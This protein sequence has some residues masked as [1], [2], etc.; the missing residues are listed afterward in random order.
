MPEKLLAMTDKSLEE[1]RQ[2]SLDHYGI[3]GSENEQEFDD[4]AKIAAYICETKICLISFVDRDRLWFKSNFGLEAKQLERQNSFCNKVVQDGGP[5]LIR[6]ALNDDRFKNNR[7]VREYPDVRFYA[8][9]A[10]INRE[11][12][13]LGT[14]CVMDSDEKALSAS[15]IEHLKALG[16]QV[17]ALLEKRYQNLIHEGSSYSGHKNS[18]VRSQTQSSRFAS[19]FLMNRADAILTPLNE[20][21]ELAQK[22]EENS[23]DQK[24]KTHS[25]SILSTSTG[26]LNLLRELLDFSKAEAGKLELQISEFSL[27]NLMNSVRALFH[28]LM[29]DKGITFE[30]KFDS[31][32]G[33]KYSG[34]LTRIQQILNQLISNSIQFTS[35]G[36]IALS[37]NLNSISTDLTELEFSVTDTGNGMSA[38]K[39]NS[40]FQQYSDPDPTSL[41]AHRGM[42][43]GLAMCK[44]LSNLMNGAMGVESIEGVGSTFLFSVK[45]KSSSDSTLKLLDASSSNHAPEVK[46]TDR[47]SKFKIL[48]AEDNLISQEISL[49]L[50]K[51]AGYQAA[52]VSNGVEVIQACASSHYDL[53]LMDCQMP[54]MDGYEATQKLRLKGSAIP[55]IALTANSFEADRDRCIQSG[56][57]DYLTKPIQH[58]VI[59]KTIDHWLF[60]GLFHKVGG[61]KELW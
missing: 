44:Q 14:L 46:I 4:L 33:R 38:V 13:A 2:N 3:L 51:K 20:M 34:D 28:P 12:F 19:Q 24:Q 29:E 54:G 9:V 56:M 42:G 11:G 45:L 41:K 27:S 58:E 6:D 18:P 30:V 61:M 60:N 52:I 36:K 31:I 5:L 48:I 10:L 57:S 53:I 17:I 26:L 7:L 23:V 35:A 8:G 22:F 59:I 25:Q 32:D 43:L 15:Q 40:L 21:I 49:R 47:R 55:I 50:L 1:L 37:V 39:S 16:H